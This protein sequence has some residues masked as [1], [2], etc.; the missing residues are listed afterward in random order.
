MLRLIIHWAIGWAIVVGVWCVT[1]PIIA[2]IFVAGIFGLGISL[3]TAGLL[4]L[5]NLARNKRQ[6]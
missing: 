5:S 1:T 4:G 6:V 3:L 2:V